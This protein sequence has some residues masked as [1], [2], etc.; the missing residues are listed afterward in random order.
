MLEKEGYMEKYP[1]KEIEINLDTI[2]E[3]FDQK[4]CRL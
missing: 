3:K 2:S 4:T 1:K